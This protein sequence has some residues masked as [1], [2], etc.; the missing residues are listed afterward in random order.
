MLER[1]RIDFRLL[2]R[3]DVA[4]P[5]YA[6]GPTASQLT[7]TFDEHALRGA[8]Q[9]SNGDPIPQALTLNVRVPCGI[10]EGGRMARLAR[11]IAMVGALFDRDREV[12]QV[13]FGDD[14]CRFLSLVQLA[15]VVDAMRCRFTFRSRP[16]ADL[17]I[18]VDFHGTA[19]DVAALAGVGFNRMTFCVQ[20]L[21]GA[22]DV[23]E[24]VRACRRHGLRSTGVRL[25]YGCPHETHRVF[26]TTLERV[27]EA[28]PDRV[29]VRAYGRAP[30]LLAARERLRASSLPPPATKLALLRMAVRRLCE[31][32]YVYIGMDQFALRADDLARAQESGDLHCDL[33][34]YTTHHETDI[35]GLGVGA[36][37]R[38]GAA[39]SQNCRDV[40]CW[41][42]AIDAG[43]LP[44]GRG[45]RLTAD[46]LMRHDLIAQILGHGEVSIAMIARRYKIDFDSYFE[47]SLRRLQPMI[48]GGLVHIANDRI[49]ISAEGRLQLRHVA[50]CFERGGEAGV[51]PFGASRL[52]ESVA[53]RVSRGTTEVRR[54]GRREETKDNGINAE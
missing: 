31:A 18:D 34:G 2:H 1:P 44:V 14:T 46:G 29:A 19:P 6:P 52:V 41:Q 12:V 53:R 47:E 21:A 10:R 15:D 16:D 38:V 43:R 8:I 26:G 17:S 11:E 35:V 36:M 32:G 9:A 23:N 4:S 50:R 49:A 27:M 48:E 51:V 37:G 40:E 33:L 54:C 7:P 28:R 5:R 13:H 39:F 42:A 20:G 45:L 3:Y 24:A 22:E 30:R 25:V